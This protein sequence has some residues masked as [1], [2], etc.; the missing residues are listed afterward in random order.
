MRIRLSTRLVIGIAVVVTAMLL[1]LV[2]NSV[3][4]INSSHMELFERSIRQETIVLANSLAPGLAVDDRAMLLDSLSLMTNRKNLVYSAVYNRDGVLLSYIGDKNSQTVN[5]QEQDQKRVANVDGVYTIAQKI[6]LAGQYMGT[7]YASYTQGEVKDITSKTRIQNTIIA[8]IALLISIV[9]TIAVGIFLKRRLY[10]L[11]MGAQKLSKG[12]LS[13]RIAIKGNN[14]ISDVAR[15]FNLMAENL[16]DMQAELQ[17]KNAELGRETGRLH[18]LLNGVNAVIIEF[19]PASCQSLYVSKEAVNLLGYETSEW[20]GD[21]F[22][23]DHIHPD[24]LVVMQAKIENNII[25]GQSYTFDYRMQHKNNEYLWVR[26]IL[27]AVDEVKIGLILRGLM[28]NITDQKKAE[29]RI[30]YLANHDALTGLMNRRRFQEELHRCIRSADRF[31]HKGAVL[32]IDLDQ[33]KYVNDSLGHQ[34]GDEYLIAVAK[35]LQESI[36]DVDI[37]GRLG[38]DEFGIIL[39]E[40]NDDDIESVATKLLALLSEEVLVSQGLQAHISAS[41]G[42]AIFPDHSNEVS[43][44]LA[45]AD[46]AMYTIKAQGRNGFHLYHDSDRQLQ[47]M[48]EKVHWEDRIKRALSEDSFLFHYQPIIEINSGDIAHYEALLR[49]YDKDNDKLIMP[50]AFID[51]AERFGLIKDIDTW[52]LEHAIQK[53]GEESAR[54]NPI[55]LAVNL[56]GRNFGSTELLRKLEYWLQH[57]KAI[58]ENLIFEVTETAA[59]ENLSQARSFI[60]SL[61]ALGCKFALDDF[62]VGFSTLHYLKHLPVDFIKIDGS[63]VRNLH[64]ETSD[65]VFVKAICDIAN[66]LGIYTIAEF[67]ENKEIHTILTELGVDEAQGYYYSEPLATMEAEYEFSNVDASLSK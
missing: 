28:I 59:V 42:G 19:D 44:L 49:I 35:C 45:K 15:S 21:Q 26:S 12:E 20:F 4:L 3:R 11:E 1:M 41:I 47:H 64:T 31:R 40:I 38:G 56:S 7:L 37:L 27:T 25:A 66:G 14:E 46:A 65:R 29:E 53:L 50:S 34:G 33:F 9:F 39:P 55:S 17:Y 10:D 54:G 6:N 13:Y 57:Y 61:R 5:P 8:V 43:D 30:V 22:L 63:F 60:E 18:T 24:D 23:C 48:Q 58:P 62:G 36:R 32:F 16:F 52:V 2:W 67:V 51:T